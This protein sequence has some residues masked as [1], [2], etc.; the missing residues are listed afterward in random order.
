MNVIVKWSSAHF[1]VFLRVLNEMEQHPFHCFPKGFQW[2]FIINFIIHFIYVIGF[3]QFHICNWS[4]NEWNW[5]AQKLHFIVFLMVFNEIE[6]SPF[7]CFP[8]EFQW[9]GDHRWSF[10]FHYWVAEW[11]WRDE[12]YICNLHIWNYIIHG[13]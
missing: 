2:N 4:P 5:V 9:N 10:Q 8:K 3:D 1:I 13:M 7:H 12:N 11:N 6:Q